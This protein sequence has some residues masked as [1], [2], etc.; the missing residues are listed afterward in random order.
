MPFEVRLVAVVLAG[1]GFD[2]AVTREY[3]VLCQTR[4]FLA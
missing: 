3:V 1:M 2:V 4:P